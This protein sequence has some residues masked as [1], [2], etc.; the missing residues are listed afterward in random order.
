MR[1][2]QQDTVDGD[3]VEGTVII[4]HSKWNYNQMAIEHSRQDRTIGHS[5]R[6][7]SRWESYNRT[8]N[9]Q[10]SRQDGTIG[11]SRWDSYNRT[12]LTGQLCYNT[13][14]QMVTMGHSTQLCRTVDGKIILGHCR[15][16]GYIRQIRTQLRQ[17]TVDGDSYNYVKTGHSRRVQ[18]QQYTLERTAMLQHSRPDGY[19]GTQQIHNYVTTVDGKI[20]LGHHRLHGYIRQIRT[21][22]I[23]QTGC[24][25]KQDSLVTTQMGTQ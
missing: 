10:H 1:Q 16:H 3:K 7:H 25:S 4:G 6:G 5:R 20:I 13:V 8:H 11:H 18:L 22:Q 2:L 14:E 15:L 17:D 23:Q 21:Q 12:H 19:I 24:Y 9:I